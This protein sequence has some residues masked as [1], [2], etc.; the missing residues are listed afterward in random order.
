MKKIL[1]TGGL[2]FLGSYSIEKWKKQGWQITIIDN[3]S[4][5][6]IE[7]DDQICDDCNIIIGNIL[8]CSWES[9]KNYDLI[10]HLASPVGPAGI[11]KHSGKMADYILSDIYW[12]AEGARLNKCPLVFVSTSEIYGH[13][14][15]AVLLKEDDDKIL[16]G[17]FSV[18][19][20]YS[21]AKL[22]CEIVL[23]NLSKVSN[24]KYHIIRPF[25]IS[26][27]RQL[28]NGGFVLPTFVTQALG[29]NPITVF[30]SGEQVRAF[31]HVKDIIDGIYLVSEAEK[32][33]YNQCWNI[34]NSSNT[35]PINELAN[36]VK[37]KTNT[38][39]EIIHVDPKTIHGPLYEE[40]W[41]KIPD[42]TK[43]E[44]LLG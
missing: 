9:L 31:T 34:G 19:N 36:I 39:S 25:N 29:S 15:K 4:T 7:P 14:D 44:N 35:C 3:L 11:L 32:D 23:S 12:A 6:V 8:D 41:D 42:A 2:G 43:A 38:E 37:A 10:L 5:N 26:G 27:A 16:R 13:R 24:L 30:N 20:E 40:A 1:I 18:R 17:S 21:M 22:L 33:L 28:I